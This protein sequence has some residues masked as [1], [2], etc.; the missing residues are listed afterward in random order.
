VDDG[1]GGRVKPGTVDAFGLNFDWQILSKVGIF[2]RYG[3]ASTQVDPS[4]PG[5]KGGNLNSQAIQFGLGFPDLGKQG[6]LG[7]LS[8]LVPFDVLSGR[9]F[10]VAGGGNGGTQYE[11]EA[12]YFFPVTNNIA[13]VPAFYLIANPNNFDDNPT[14]YVGNLRAQF[15]F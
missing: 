10:L 2:G 3:Y 15:S 1:Q 12:T 14:I 6:A 13:I 9:K 4:T 8:F 11:L 7:T 5:V